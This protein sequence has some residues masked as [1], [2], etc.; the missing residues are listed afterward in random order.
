VTLMKGSIAVESAPGSGSVFR[1]AVPLRSVDGDLAGR[2]G[3]PR[4]EPATLSGSVRVMLVD[5]D[6]V[7]RTI[8]EAALKDLGAE[9][10]TAEGGEHALQR[11]AHDRVDLILMDCQMPGMDGFAVTRRWREREV[12]L[13]RPR[14]PIVAL[15]GE[16]CPEIRQACIAAGMDDYLAKPVS[17]Q[18]LTA[19]ISRW[20][21]ATPVLDGPA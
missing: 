7:N 1:V 3:Q 17:R 8:M 5:D 15:T 19:M 11:L 9:V 2:S 21:M 4:T 18:D 14:V 10:L 6:P 20:T 16:T 13:G 12:E